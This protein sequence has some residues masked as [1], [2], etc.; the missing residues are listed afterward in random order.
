VVVLATRYGGNIKLV[1]LEITEGETG[2]LIFEAVEDAEE[3]A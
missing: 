3:F 1:S 2:I